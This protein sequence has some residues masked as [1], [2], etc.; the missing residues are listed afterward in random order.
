MEATSSIHHRRRSGGAA[1]AVNARE[2]ERSEQGKVE[3]NTYKRLM[4]EVAAA[5]AWFAR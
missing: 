4:G 1:T 2:E 3:H 5:S